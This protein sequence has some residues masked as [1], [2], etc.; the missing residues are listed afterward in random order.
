MASFYKYETVEIP[1]TF[2][3]SGILEGYSHIIISLYQAGTQIDKTEED[4]EIDIANN[5]ITL[6]LDQEETGLFA[7]GDKNDAKKVIIQVNIYYNNNKRS[8]STKGTID[9][10]DNLYKQVIVDE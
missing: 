5:K 2:T 1:I 8:V 9:V 3:P 10:Y 6:S 4:L 7:G